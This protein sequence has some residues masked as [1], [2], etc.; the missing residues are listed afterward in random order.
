M[1]P[2]LHRAVSH[3]EGGSAYSDAQWA[4][5]WLRSRGVRLRSRPFSAEYLGNVA[6]ILF[7]D[8]LAETVV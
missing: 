5:Q 6:K 1:R 4:S 3:S 8:V 7:G 2:R